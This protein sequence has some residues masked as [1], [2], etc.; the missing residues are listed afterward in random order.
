MPWN[1]RVGDVEADAVP[2]PM[3]VDSGLQERETLTD[4]S[5]ARSRKRLGGSGVLSGSRRAWGGGGTKGR[6]GVVERL[7]QKLE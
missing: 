1:V 5:P 7:A 4:A 3:L 6:R 2:G